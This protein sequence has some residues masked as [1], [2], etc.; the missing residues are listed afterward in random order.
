[1][2]RIMAEENDTKGMSFREIRYQ[3][4]RDAIIKSAAKAFGQKG[5]HGATIEDITNEHKMTKGSMYYYFSTKEDLLY[6]VHIISLNKVIENTLK[7][8]ETDDPPYVKMKAAIRKHLE[9]LAREFEGAF[10]LQYEFQLPE[11]PLKK[12]IAMRNVYERDFVQII[13]DGI[14]AGIFRVKN[15]RL[16]A[17]AILGSINWFLRWYS[18]SGPWS[19]EEIADGYVD[20]FCNGLLVENK[21]IQK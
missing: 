4:K 14:K 16:A 12:I 13:E 3:E 19:I 9:V 15:A 6:E 21:K 8:N 5:F 18:S 20:L 17:F 1:M 2:G 7:I 11:E 10:M